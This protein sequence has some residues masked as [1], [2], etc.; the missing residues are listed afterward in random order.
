MSYRI[1]DIILASLVAVLLSPLMLGIALLLKLR[2]GY[3]LFLQQRPGY[4]G[5]PFYI[6][7]FRTMDPS[8]EGP[9]FTRIGKFLQRSSLDE[10]PQV[11]NVLKGD[12]SLV[13]PRPLLMEY[14]EHYSAEQMRRH[15]LR[16]GITGWAQVNG[17]SA[18]TFQK[19]F[20][21]D[22]WYV[23]HRSHRLDLKIFW[24]TFLKVLGGVNAIH[25]EERYDGSN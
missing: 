19:R 8:P 23:D 13:G 14:L 5:K 25:S 3:V 7:K 24:M 2:Y 12:M 10:L 6:Y 18:I 1:R 20:E 21:M 11:F 15:D 4:K 16:P 22:V 9:H 17:R